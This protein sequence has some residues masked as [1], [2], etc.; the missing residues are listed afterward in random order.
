VIT[1]FRVPPP[2]IDISSGHARETRC[3]LA[4]GFYLRSTDSV[5]DASI[6]GRAVRRHCR[7][8]CVPE[9]EATD[10]DF[11]NVDHQTFVEYKQPIDDL[12]IGA[13]VVFDTV[14]DARDLVA[15]A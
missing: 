15:A 3:F 1:N 14:E 5:E 13:A 10:I 9:T 2:A 8:G 7:A 12:M 11:T 4:G 6:T